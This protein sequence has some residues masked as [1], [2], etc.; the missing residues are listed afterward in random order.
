MLGTSMVVK[1][2][3]GSSLHTSQ[4]IEHPGFVMDYAEYRLSLS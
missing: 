1:F 4:A 2:L 3:Y